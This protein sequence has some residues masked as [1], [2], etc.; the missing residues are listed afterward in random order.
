[1]LLWFNAAGC[2]LLAGLFFT[3]SAFAMKALGRM[4]PSGGI[5]A[6]NSINET[7]LRS[8]F[9]PLFWGTT[10][11]SLGLAAIAL[12]GW[13]EPAAKSMLIG[14][15]VYIFGMFVC[16]IAIEVPLNNELARVDPGSDAAL[17]VWQRYQRRWTG[18]NHVRTLACLVACV[19]FIQALV[20]RG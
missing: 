8:L 16:T 14:G 9:M 7:I 19:L 3:F 18:W 5:A 1:M 17:P 4:E 13:N 12:S 20:E 2:G 6:M 10:L 11:A 15:L